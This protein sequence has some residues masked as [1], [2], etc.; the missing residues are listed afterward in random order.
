MRN[1][2]IRNA[3]MVDDVSK[4]FRASFLLLLPYNRTV[5]QKDPQLQLRMLIELDSMGG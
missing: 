4:R 3:Q 2:I 1:L 5:G